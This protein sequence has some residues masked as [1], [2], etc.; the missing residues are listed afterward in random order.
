MDSPGER[1]I[2]GG[3]SQGR[4]AQQG[5]TET[6][7]GPVD[8]RPVE[9]ADHGRS[10]LAFRAKQDCAAMK[11]VAPAARRTSQAGGKYR[12]TRHVRAGRPYRV[13]IRAPACCRSTSALSRVQVRA[14]CRYSE[15]AR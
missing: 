11:G 4:Q 6:D 5:E 10:A 15:R 7:E 2:H 12:L 3:I 9:R 13:E 1:E 14:L 8:L